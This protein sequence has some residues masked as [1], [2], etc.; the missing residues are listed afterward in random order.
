MDRAT[1]VAALMY[2]KLTDA[3]EQL[4]Q[5]RDDEAA[6]LFESMAQMTA[7]FIDRRAR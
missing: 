3:A 6:R 5:D 1:F 4:R 7:A 2:V